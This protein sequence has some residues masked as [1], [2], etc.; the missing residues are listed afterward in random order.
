MTTITAQTVKFDATPVHYEFTAEFPTF[1]D[2]AAFAALFPKSH[3]MQATTL[4]KSDGTRV[5]YIR[6]YA[7][8]AADDVNGGTNETAIKRYRAL[9]RKIEALGATIVYAPQFVNSY[10]SRADFEAAVGIA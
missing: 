8:L 3:K 4:G 1:E 2:A 6:H 10:A 9:S 7:W 5:G